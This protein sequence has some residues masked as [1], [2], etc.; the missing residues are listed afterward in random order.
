MSELAGLYR[1]YDRSLSAKGL[2]DRHDKELAA[3]RHLRKAGLFP[4]CSTECGRTLQRDLR[5]VPAAACP[6]GGAVPPSSRRADAPLEPPAW[7]PLR[8][9]RKNGRCGGGPRQRR[10]AAGAVFAEPTGHFLTPLLAAVFDRWA[11]N[12]G[13]MPADMALIAAPGPYRECEEI[14]RR[15]RRLLE[16][17][18]DPVAVA[19]VLR[20]LQVTGRCSRM[21]AAVSGFPSPT[22]AAPRCLPP[23]SCGP[24]SPRLPSSAPDSAARNSWG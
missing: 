13:E 1:E 12:E 3:L 6:A 21:S 2:L 9:C 22:G 11:A 19:V 20:D 5:S 15:I 24:A 7:L 18:T 23:P 4:L 14:G 17:G 10:S 8:V 16:A